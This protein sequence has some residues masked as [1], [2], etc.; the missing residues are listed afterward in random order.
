SELTDIVVPLSDLWGAHGSA[1]ALELDELGEAARVDRLEAELVRRLSSAA[2]RG[3][4]GVNVVGLASWITRSRGQQ[5][6][7]QLSD[8]AGVSRQQLARLFRERVG[9]TP[10]VYSRL[11]RFQCG[12]AYLR[13][14]ARV[15]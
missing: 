11:A 9:V 4:S 8:A 7:E 14:D 2:L 5:S 10:K 3:G 1:L 15:P 12:L 13:P 6:V